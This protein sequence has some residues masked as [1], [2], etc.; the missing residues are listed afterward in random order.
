MFEIFAGLMALSAILSFIN[1]KFLKLP[2]GIGVM[3][4]AIA[5]SFL[6]WSSQWINPEFFL[7]ACQIVEELDFKSLVLNFLLSFLLFAG[8]IHVNLS[9]ILQ[10]KTSVISFATFGVVF[11][12]LFIGVGVYLFA[13]WIGVTI[14]L[15]EALV[16]GALVSPT[17]PVA[18]LSLL[19]KAKVKEDV[20]IK[21]VGESLFN[22]GVGILLF[23]TLVMLL[24]SSGEHAQN[25]FSLS[26]V[27]THFIR[28]A[29]GGLLLGFILG[30][31]G[32]VFSK[33]SEEEAQV[34]THITIAIVMGGYALSEAIQVSGPLAMVV[35]GLMMGKSLQ[36]C[37]LNDT[38]R[39]SLRNFWKIID[40]IF[41]AVLFLLIGLEVL[42]VEFNWIHLLMG[43]TAIILM[44][45][46]RYGGI[47][48][49][50][51]FLTKSHRS[52]RKSALILTWAGLRGGLSMALALSLPEGEW[53]T[54][55]VFMT[56][57]VVLFSILVQGL[58][59]GKLVKRLYT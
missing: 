52:D 54:G 29:G 39:F 10:E 46:S 26:S 45:V 14:S 40:E 5:S 59:I 58:S 22:D 47:W 4:L 55:L 21:I 57:V 8:A 18:V 36:D 9:H 19:K 23:I 38:V 16:F 24:P 34:L 13:Q 11:S 7:S 3:I 37:A 17:D 53:R 32:S 12:T 20:E 48:I 31:L 15:I 42:S 43:F 25:S 6:L 33:Y 27:F 49:T 44:L 35:A 2:S 50:N 56:Y 28:E 30:W 41:N 1:Y 51:L